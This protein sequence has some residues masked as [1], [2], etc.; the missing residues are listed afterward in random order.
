[1][2]LYHITLSLVFVVYSGLST[3]QY[4]VR[5][6]QETP[7]RCYNTLNT[8]RQMPSSLATESPGCL[9]FLHRYQCYQENPII[10]H[11]NDDKQS[12]YLGLYANATSLPYLNQIHNPI[13]NHTMPKVFISSFF[14]HFTQL[15]QLGSDQST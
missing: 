10:F 6:Y 12:L 8:S 13:Y 11:L 5:K 4:R 3:Q 9:Q 2:A 14:P 7:S 15:S 1:M